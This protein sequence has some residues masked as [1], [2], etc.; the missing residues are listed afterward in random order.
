MTERKHLKSSVRA[1]MARTGERYAAARAHVVTAR[2]D[3]PD[4]TTAPDPHGPG[5]TTAGVNPATA[6]L[7][8]LL[9]SAGAPVSEPLALVL[10][11]GIGM[12][13]FQF[14]Y[15]KEGV[16]TFFLAGRHRWDDDHAYLVDALARLGLAA[17]VTET[18]SV[19]TADRQ[20]RDA[21]APGRPVVAWVDLA[22]LETR[23]YPAEYRG[24]AYHVVV[25][26]SIDDARGVAVLDDLASVPVEVSLDVLS[27]ARARIA[28]ARNRLLTIPGSADP[29]DA[30]RLDTA[31]R[32]GLAATVVGLDG[33]RT[34]AFS[35][36][37]LADWSA[38][39][40][41][42]GRDS[43]ATVF[44]PG[45]RLWSGLAAI[46]EYVEH[47]GAGGGLLRPSFAAGLREAA[48]RLDDDRLADLADR[49]DRLGAGWTDLARAALPDGVPALRRTR[50]LQ[51]LRAVRYVAAGAGA[52]EE[53]TAAWDA[54]AAIRTEV[55]DC[56]PLDA[57][58]TRALLDGLA[59]RV[60]AL[61]ADE[62]AALDAVRA[63][64][65]DVTSGQ[66]VA[67][68]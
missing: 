52:H 16:S 67:H 26:R 46:H 60:A 40:R 39:L 13:I 6:A 24:G 45:A 23:A 2:G 29:P 10:G 51:D 34:R 7:R 59:D 20:L 18:G 48:D 50:D 56:F 1:R 57:D 4:R 43:W 36:D 28:K 33:P 44:P 62:A 61:H 38:R 41:G 8:A 55:D 35:L 68:P 12:G 47:W 9:A 58:Q 63:L 42:T 5:T 66:A 17:H 11:G 49:Y 14:H 65:G 25:V 15:A 22:E 27:R 64:T 19:R 30:G 31:L 21:V 37:A 32:G 53:L 54:L 3:D